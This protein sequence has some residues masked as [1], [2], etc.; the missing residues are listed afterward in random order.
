MNPADRKALVTKLLTLAGI[1][2]CLAVAESVF[3]IAA[4]SFY[5]AKWLRLSPVIEI[6]AALSIPACAYFGAKESNR[7]LLGLFLCCSFCTVCFDCSCCIVITI[8]GFVYVW[9]QLGKVKD[10]QNSM[11]NPVEELLACGSWPCGDAC[12][13]ILDFTKTYCAYWGNEHNATEFTGSGTADDESFQMTPVQFAECLDSTHDHWNPI[14]ICIAIGLLLVT[15]KLCFYLRSV[16]PG[17]ELLEEV[18]RTIEEEEGLIKN[19]KGNQGGQ[20]GNV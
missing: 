12:D 17:G 1:A 2:A 20:Q 15:C 5:E 19:Q 4:A 7:S 8:P 6:A 10:C 9:M 18:G 13:S 14:L 3:A 11:P 16:G